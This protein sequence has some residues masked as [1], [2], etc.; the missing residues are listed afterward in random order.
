MDNKVKYNGKKCYIH[1]NYF[2]KFSNSFKIETIRSGLSRNDGKYYFKRK[3]IAGYYAY[4]T[5]KN[6]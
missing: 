2:K 6:G 5:L 1:H 3:P 4:R